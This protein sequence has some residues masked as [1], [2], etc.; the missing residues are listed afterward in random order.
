MA[1]TPAEIPKPPARRTQTQRSVPGTSTALRS[2]SLHFR[3][4]RPVADALENAAATERLTVSAWVASRVEERLR[5]AGLFG[6]E[7]SLEVR[8]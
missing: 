6:L 3:V 1:A 2:C 8:R 4:T 5:A 7:V